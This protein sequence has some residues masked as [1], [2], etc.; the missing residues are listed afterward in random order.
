MEEVFQLTRILDWGVASMTLP[1]QTLSGDLHLVTPCQDGAMAAVVDGVGHGVEANDAARRAIDLLKKYAGEPIIWLAQHCHAVLRSTRG[2]V[3]TV[4]IFNAR[5]STLTALGIGNVETVLLRADPRG[6]PAR[7]TVLLRAGVV[8]YQ[9]PALQANVFPVFRGDLLLLGTDGVRP[10]FADRLK[11]AD[12]P[13]FLAD[14][15]LEKNF[16]GTDD[17]LVLA[18]RYLGPSRD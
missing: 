4:A 3:M 12:S 18:V 8:G 15:L 7:E 10:G 2:V 5:E 13:Q 16:R 9:L 1:G 14:Q 17:A 6:T 11:F